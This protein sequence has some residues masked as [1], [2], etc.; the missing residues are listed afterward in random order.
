[1]LFFCK[2]G[3]EALEELLVIFEF[4]DALLLGSDG[5]LHVLDLYIVERLRN[6]NSTHTDIDVTSSGGVGDLVVVV[7][8]WRKAVRFAHTALT[9]DQPIGGNIREHVQQ[10]VDGGIGH[11]GVHIVHLPA[12]TSSQRFVAICKHSEVHLLQIEEVTDAVF[13]Q[14]F[15][16]CYHKKVANL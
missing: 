5:G 9:H 15:V 14:N 11:G 10:Q 16:V 7:H 1:M 8:L 4:G 3:E 12:I 6:G 13:E 2:G